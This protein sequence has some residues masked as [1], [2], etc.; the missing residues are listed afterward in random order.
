MSGKTILLGFCL[1]ISFSCISQKQ[2]S[3]TEQV[4][5]GYVNQTRFSNKLGLWVDF[6]L[7]TRQNF[8]S[9]FSQAVGRVGLAYYL[10]NN[11]VFAAGYAYFNHF[12]SDNHNIS[13]P[14]HRLWQQVQWNNK[15][16]RVRFTQRVRLE[17]R[18]QQ[19]ILNDNELG[20]GY[21]FNWRGRYNFVAA[22]SLAKKA[23]APKTWSVVLNDEI[24]FNA[25][26]EIVYNSFDQNRFFAGFAYHLNTHDNIQVGYMNIFKQLAAGNKYKS[27]HVARLFYFHNLD[28]RKNE[29]H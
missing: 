4:W 9:N 17:E 24:M 27:T 20:E 3:Y 25:G 28:L 12:P 6:H 1:M 7:R 23:F 14:E 8:F 11:T 19:K 10:N 26:R 5:L 29:K 15:Y 22:F 21:H 2:T 16:S 13:R 18:F